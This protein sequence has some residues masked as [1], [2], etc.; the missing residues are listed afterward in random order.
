MN[1]EYQ[2]EINLLSDLAE[3][4]KNELIQFGCNINSRKT[5]EE[6][7]LEYF[8]VRKRLIY[9]LPRKV[10]AASEYSCP[11][12][13]AAGI[14]FI[15]KKIERGGNLTPHLSDKIIKPDYNDYLLND[16]GTYHLHLGTVDDTRKPGFIER[17]ILLLFA[18]FDRENAYFINVMNHGFWT[19]Q[20]MIEVID[21]NWPDTISGYKLP[22][23]IDPL[24]RPTNS[25]IKD[26]RNTQINLSIKV[27]SGRVYMSMGGGYTSSGPSIE[28]AMSRNK[29]TSFARKTEKY[30]KEEVCREIKE[31]KIQPKEKLRFKYERT[32]DDEFVVGVNVDFKRP[33]KILSLFPPHPTL[34]PR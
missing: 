28:A 24:L 12:E 29:I 32:D 13:V 4:F 33:V 21:E 34:I 7:I 3:A 22:D 16:W 20:K 25:Q 27:K 18:R 31:G 14:E 26:L 17:T 1:K 23:G 15:K 9:P 19:E 2:I 8:N 6:I 5:L 30:I 11:P 10:L